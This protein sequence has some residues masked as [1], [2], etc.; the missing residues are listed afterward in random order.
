M[1]QNALFE[2]FFES[3]IGS[4][5]IALTDRGLRIA[6]TIFSTAT[7]EAVRLNLETEYSMGTY[8]N[9]LSKAIIEDA[10]IEKMGPLKKDLR[11]I[12]D[13]FQKVSDARNEFLMEFHGWNFLRLKCT[14]EMEEVPT[15]LD[16]AV[17]NCNISSVVK[18]TFKFA[19]G[20]TV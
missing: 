6:L 18:G 4:E 5:D 10:C 20:V 19:A 11:K 16:Y 2:A 1:E 7:R 17:Y 13:L 3:F 8:R 15:S 14:E 12:I 9:C